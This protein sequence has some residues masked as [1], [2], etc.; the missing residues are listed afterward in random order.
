MSF[1]G[2][3]FA[4]LNSFLADDAQLADNTLDELLRFISSLR[5]KRV[6]KK[7]ESDALEELLFNNRCLVYTPQPHILPNT[8][9]LLDICSLL[10]RKECW[11]CSISR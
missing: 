3:C 6:I 10:R 8:T 9:Q 11:R 4:L 7:S 1:I 2:I 5:V